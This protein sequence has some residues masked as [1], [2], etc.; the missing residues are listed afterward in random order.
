MLFMWESTLPPL[1]FLEQ[2]KGAFTSSERGFVMSDNS[3]EASSSASFFSKIKL[4]LF[5]WLQALVFALLILILS[6][7]F[8]GRI[9]S[10]EG[11]SMYPT[12]HD[13]DMLLLQCAGYKPGQGDIVVLNKEFGSV[14]SPIVKRI[15]ATGGQTVEIDYEDGLVYVDDVALEEPYLSE[16]MQTPQSSYETITYAEVPEGYVF[17]MGD[18]RNA[19]SDSRDVRLGVVDERYILGRAFFVLLPFSSFGTIDSNHAS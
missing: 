7:T 16:V 4:D 1:V 12:L 18:N 9:I 6:F 10:V 3:M 11:S 13:G 14:T 19:S 17:V 2:D 8:F 15:I 5:S